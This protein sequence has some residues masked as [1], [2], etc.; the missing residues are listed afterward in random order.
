[1]TTP[2]DMAERHGRMLAEL[3]EIGLSAARVL[4]E[5]L[6]AAEDAQASADLGLALHRMS[7]SVR[8]TLAL[9]AKLARDA[10]RADREACERAVSHR[11][12]R[13][14]AAVE[15]LIW[16]EA[17]DDETADTRLDAFDAFL[18]ALSLDDDF[19]DTPIEAQIARICAAMD[20]PAPPSGNLR[21]AK[22]AETLSRLAERDPA[23]VGLRANPDHPRRSSA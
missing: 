8:Q 5:R 6:L 3:A 10:Q 18:D 17:G 23:S 15:P 9:E 12:A 4:H 14:K 13:V 19:L 16:T 20:I 7:R 21:T 22:D 1:M 11:K 2:A